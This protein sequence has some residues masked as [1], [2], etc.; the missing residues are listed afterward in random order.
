MKDLVFSVI[1]S[2]KRFY[3]SQMD[4]LMQFV[5]SLM[6]VA[7][8]EEFQEIKTHLDRAGSELVQAG[9]II[10][11][12]FGRMEEDEDLHEAHRESMEAAED[13]ME[14]VEALPQLLSF[15]D[16]PETSQAIENFEEESDMGEEHPHM[17]TGPGETVSD[18]GGAKIVH[19]ETLAEAKVREDMLNDPETI[20]EIEDGI[21]AH[22]SV[23]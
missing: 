6:E 21:Y 5:E 9:K 16:F 20:L 10:H 2:A 19:D 18:F 13:Y 8:E 17:Y 15:L 11:S 12:I 4:F 3:N 14:K 1:S 23:I 7:S 22:P